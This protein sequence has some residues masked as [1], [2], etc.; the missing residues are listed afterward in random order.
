MVSYQ[1]KRWLLR[2]RR[3]CNSLLEFY[4]V[5]YDYRFSVWFFTQSFCWINFVLSLSLSPWSSSKPCSMCLL[6]I[7]SF[8]SIF[9]SFDYFTIP[10]YSVCSNFSADLDSIVVWWLVARLLIIY[11]IDGLVFSNIVSILYW[12]PNDNRRM[13]FTSIIHCVLFDFY[14]HWMEIFQRKIDFH[15]EQQHRGCRESNTCKIQEKN[16]VKN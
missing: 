7:F 6:L 15:M 13:H 16:I 4:I 10:T 8:L 5:V 9:L 11:A 2:R 12:L 14:Y 3:A 1:S